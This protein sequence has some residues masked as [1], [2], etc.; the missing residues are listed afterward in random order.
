VIKFSRFNAASLFYKETSASWVHKKINFFHIF[1]FDPYGPITPAVC[2]I[3]KSESKEVL[4]NQLSF[5][6][7]QNVLGKLKS[8]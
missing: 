1:L 7:N 5:Y 3:T 4:H 2:H 6:L 8:N